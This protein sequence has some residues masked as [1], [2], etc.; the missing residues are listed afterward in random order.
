MEQQPRGLPD[1]YRLKSFSIPLQTLLPLSAQLIE[2][3]CSGGASSSFNRSLGLIVAIHNASG[4]SPPK[5]IRRKPPPSRTR[6]LEGHEWDRLLSALQQESPLLAQAARFAVATGMRENNVINLRWDQVDLTTRRAYVEAAET[7]QRASLGIPLTDDAMAVLR[8]RR[9][10]N[11]VYVFAHPDSGLPLVK[12]SNRAWYS[13]VRKAK[14]KG[15]RWHDLRHTWASWAIQSGVRIEQLMEL[16]GWK[17]LS[18]VK[19]YSH[20]NTDHLAEVAA[21]I[22]PVRRGND[23]ISS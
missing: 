1:R 16:G 11:K 6:W 2:K 18:M 17:S 12:A 19:R 13:A 14:L 22:R 23:R 7:K 3:C 9:G 4:I 10:S 8:E 5:V 21:K 20:M 15:F